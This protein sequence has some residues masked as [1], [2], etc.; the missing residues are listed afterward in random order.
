MSQSVLR[1]VVVG[2]CCLCIEI[3]AIDGSYAQSS[4]PAA[5]TTA[6]MIG[7]GGHGL[8]EG[9]HAAP[10]G[11]KAQLEFE[12]RGGLTSDY[13]YRGVTLSDRKPAVGMA[14]EATYSLL[15]A[16]IT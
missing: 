1:A 4:A 15:Y 11:A 14:I 13:V 3:F 8:T 2:A 7:L 9:R 12:V 10:D 5:Q 6:G 16:G